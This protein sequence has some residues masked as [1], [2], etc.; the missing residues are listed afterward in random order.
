MSDDLS[1]TGRIIR[2]EKD[3]V[4][5]KTGTYWNIEVFDIRWYSNDKPSRKGIRLNKEEA[6]KLYEILRRE[7]E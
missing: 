4:I 1:I 2:N 3:E 6:E 7:F 5:V